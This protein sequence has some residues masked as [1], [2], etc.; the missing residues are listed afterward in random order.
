[1]ANWPD[2]VPWIALGFTEVPQDGT[3]RTAM[4]AGAA[5]QRPRF[6]AVSRAIAASAVL[7]AAQY[8]ALKAFYYTTLAGGSL[9]F[10]QIDPQ[11]GASATWRFNGPPSGAALRAD[12]ET[13][14]ADLWS[15]SLPLEILP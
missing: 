5:K 10:E 8:A 15:V 12:G 1:M 9:T 3:I 2:N 14:T 11:T 13:L 7:T 6:S 4:S